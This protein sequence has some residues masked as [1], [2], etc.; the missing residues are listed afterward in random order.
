[1][2]SFG[3][4][5]SKATSQDAATILYQPGIRIKFA[6]AILLM[7]LPEVLVKV[8]I[9]PKSRVAHLTL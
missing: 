5:V 3:A 6:N 1:M 8:I 7:E 2:K 9:G 4:R